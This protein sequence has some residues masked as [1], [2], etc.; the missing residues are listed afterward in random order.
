MLRHCITT[1]LL[2]AVATT[3]GAAPS[4]AR[5]ARV[6][7]LN[8]P[9]AGSY[10]VRVNGAPRG[11]VAAGPGGSA[12]IALTTNPQDDVLFVLT[13]VD[14]VTPAAPDGFNAAGSTQGCVT[15]TWNTPPPGDYVTDY[16]LLWGTRPGV[17]TD[18]T[19]VG[20]LDVVN[21]GGTSRATICGFATGTFHFILRAHN[22]FD[23]WSARSVPSTTSISNENTQG[24]P[25]PTNVTAS[26]SPLG[27]MRVAW[28]ASGDPS[29]TGYRIYLGTKSRTGG[30]Y[31]D[32]LEVGL[33]TSA[34]FCAL[35]PGRYYAAVRSR[36]AGGIL[37]A[38]SKELSLLVVGPDITP[39]QVSGM[40]PADAAVN[41][42]RNATV[43]FVLTD[44]RSGINRFS[45]T[46]RVGGQLCPARGTPTPEGGYAVQCTPADVLPAMSDVAVEVTARDNASPPNEV[47]TSWTFRTGA[48]AVNDIDPPVIA[49]PTPA[50][51]AHNVSPSSAIGVTI[52]DAGLGV[53]F[54]SVVM[55]VD[56][57]EVPVAVDGTPTSARITWKPDAGLEPGK[58]V[59]VR[60]TACD[61]AGIANCSEPFAFS[62]TVGTLQVATEPGAI[63]PD[64]FWADDPDRPM[65]VR[66]LPVSWRVRIF[67]TAGVQV[68]HFTNSQ[69][70]QTWTWDFR[71]DS[72]VRVA[73]ALYLVR[74][75]DES[76]IVRESARFLVQ[77]R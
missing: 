73:P 12:A 32:S 54:T 18:S 31:T 59:Q 24:P 27:C 28:S 76:G 22:S 33:A 25:A 40:S 69:P 20:W 42:P 44:D 35:T 56:G 48:D 17:Y 38:Y 66:N 55:L 5:D 72:G 65:E 26:E 63:V 75:T 11:N 68:R 16:R 50:P 47:R 2:A 71:N 39:P 19:H 41:V 53:D 45:I 51:D 34:S 61:N 15:L 23:L 14:P 10:E 70:G 60:V 13:G 46:V 62:F 43:F 30:A 8:V 4:E 74:V 64:G 37:S 36:T 77:S 21:A 57:T 29:V 49:N 52:S 3:L 1:I 58:T 7:L 6:L 67:D 9:P